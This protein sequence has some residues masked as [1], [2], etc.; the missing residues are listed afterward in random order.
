MYVD[1]TDS[2][3]VYLYTPKM[4]CCITLLITIFHSEG[5][6]DG[7]H[8]QSSL[9]GYSQLPF[10]AAFQTHLKSGTEGRWELLYEKNYKE[11]IR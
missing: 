3:T 7:S 8:A 11:A 4:L 2:S 6:S 10:P 1:V 5:F 9:A